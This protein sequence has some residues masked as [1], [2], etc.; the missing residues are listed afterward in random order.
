MSPDPQPYRIVI[1]GKRNLADRP[2][3]T[4]TRTEWGFTS[5]TTDYTV[6]TPLP[7][8]QLD[9]AVDTDL[10]GKAHRRTGLT[11]TPSHLKG[12]AGAGAIRAV[13]LEVSYDD[14]V[15]WHEATLQQSGSDWTA[16]LDAPSRARFASLR[17]T[18]RDTEGNSVSQ[19]VIRAFGLK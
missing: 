3:S 5:G 7:L 9:Y 8:V 17:T 10:S 16:Q 11:V 2:Y 13:T 6:L 1:E 18:A 4:R 12:A 15:T 19:T 14:G